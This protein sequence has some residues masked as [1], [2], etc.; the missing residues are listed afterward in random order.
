VHLAATDQSFFSNLIALYTCSDAGIGVVV[1]SEIFNLLIIVG[2]A[3]LAAPNLI[4]FEKG[5]FTRDCGF[6]AASI[7]LVYWTFLDQ[8][9]SM[10]ESS[11]LLGAAVVYVLAVYFTTDVVNCI[12]PSNGDE[13]EAPLADGNATMG[14]MHGVQVEVTEQLGPHAS[15]GTGVE[16][17]G[18]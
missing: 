16:H 3:T 7:G 13:L 12:A 11:I 2:C 6:Y 9:I 1:G 10:F 4:V 15:K 5:P 14:N 8:K 18:V 17:Y